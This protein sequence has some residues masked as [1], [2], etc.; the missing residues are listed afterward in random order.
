MWISNFFFKIEFRVEISTKLVLRSQIFVVQILKPFLLGFTFSIFY[1]LKYMVFSNLF[2]IFSTYRKK[3]LYIFKNCR[4]LQ[5]WVKSSFCVY[6]AFSETSIKKYSLKKVRTIGIFES[7]EYM[8]SAEWVIWHTFGGM[9]WEFFDMFFGM[10]GLVN[11][12]SDS[13]STSKLR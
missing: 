10:F 11:V 13:I 9:F 4:N 12:Y 7:G 6:L 3:N 2:Q 8:L 5:K 1:F